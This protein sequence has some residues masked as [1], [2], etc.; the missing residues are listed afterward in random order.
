MAGIELKTLLVAGLGGI[1]PTFLWLWFWMKNDEEKPEPKRMIAVTYLVGLLGVLLM[2][3]LQGI[4]GNLPT[5]TTTTIIFAGIEELLKFALVALVAFHA[6]TIDEPTDYA[7]YLI[8][9]ALGF[10]A[11]ENSLYLIAIINQGDTASA[12]LAGNM[13]FLGSTV[14]HT[15]TVAIIGIMIGLAFW[16]SKTSKIIHGIIGIAFA[17]GLHTLFNYFILVD[18]GQSI[19]TTFAGLWFVALIIIIIFQRL[20]DLGSQVPPEQSYVQEKTITV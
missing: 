11:L 13:R 1:L 4:V 14:L 12:I 8:T 2:L 5:G 19:L 17:I 7:V 3:P 15:V 10:S 9:G 18:T 16:K 6:A 20:K